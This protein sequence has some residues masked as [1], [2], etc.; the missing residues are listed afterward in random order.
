MKKP[1][2]VIKLAFLYDKSR[3]EARRM[4]KKQEIQ[5]L[6]QL[7]TC[8]MRQKIMLMRRA[9]L[10]MREKPPLCAGQGGLCAKT[11]VLCASGYLVLNIP[12]KSNPAAASFDKNRGVTG[13]FEAPLSR[14]LPHLHIAFPFTLL[15]N[16]EKHRL[17]PPLIL[18]KKIPLLK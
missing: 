16:R 6:F 5:G 3:F 18:N 1:V 13:T 2:F 11:T 15:Y 7:P 14:N 12:Q 8:S 4:E 9:P 17:Q 10:S